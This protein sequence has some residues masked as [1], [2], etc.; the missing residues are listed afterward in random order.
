MEKKKV[1]GILII[2]IAGLIIAVGA[3]LITFITT[4]KA[5]EPNKKLETLKIA[6]QIIIPSP[7]TLPPLKGSLPSSQNIST[8]SSVISP[9]LIPISSPTTQSAQ[10]TPSASLNP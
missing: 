8:Q 10:T 2:S 6:K 9:S 1:N 4:Q 5:R 3:F 7:A